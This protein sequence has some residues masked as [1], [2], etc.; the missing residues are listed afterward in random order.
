MGWDGVNIGMRDTLTN[1][2]TDL[3]EKGF[4]KGNL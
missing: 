2:F 1:V 4:L 3:S